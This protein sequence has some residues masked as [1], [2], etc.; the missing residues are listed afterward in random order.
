MFISVITTVTSFLGIKSGKHTINQKTSINNKCKF[1]LKLSETKSKL[2]NDQIALNIIQN[3]CLWLMG[4]LSAD[5]QQIRVKNLVFWASGAGCVSCHAQTMFILAGDKIIFQKDLDDPQVSTPKINGQYGLKIKVPIRQ[6]DEPLCCPTHWQETIY[7][8]DK[9]KNEF[10]EYGNDTGLYI[11]P[12]ISETSV[13]TP[14]LNMSPLIDCLGP[15]NNCTLQTQATCDQFR[16]GWGLESMPKPVYCKTFFHKDYWMYSQRDCDRAN[17]IPINH[18]IS[19][20]NGLVCSGTQFS[21]INIRCSQQGSCKEAIC[22][23]TTN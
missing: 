11:S 14:P 1:D 4:S 22:K 7:L 6:Q 9:T 2:G 23:V 18:C 10:K 5:L 21:N 8:W 16:K 17:I 12:T 3:K 15:D 13:T 20:I 19:T